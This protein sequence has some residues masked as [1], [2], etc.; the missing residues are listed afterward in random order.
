[1]LREI[2]SLMALINNELCPLMFSRHCFRSLRSLFSLAWVIRDYVGST[3]I[4]HDIIIL[5]S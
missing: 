1:M 4:V 2:E 5:L 3:I